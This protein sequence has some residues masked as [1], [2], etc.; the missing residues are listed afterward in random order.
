MCENCHKKKDRCSKKCEKKCKKCC[1]RGPV[2]PTGAQGPTGQQG[3]TGAQGPTGPAGIQGPTGPAGIQGSTGQQGPTGSPGV[4]GPTGPQGPTGA[5][6]PLIGFA[7]ALE[8]PT[9]ATGNQQIFLTENII[10]FNNDFTQ[11]FFDTSNIYDVFTGLFIVPVTGIYNITT[12]LLCIVNDNSDFNGSLNF[13][14]KIE[15]PDPNDIKYINTLTKNIA[16]A[17]AYEIY[18][19]SSIDLSLNQDDQVSIIIKPNGLSSGVFDAYVKGKNQLFDQE[20][21]FSYPSTF[22]AALIAQF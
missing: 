6:G 22:S 17:T 10:L 11:P 5:L 19:N 13:Y 15:R 8:G 4:D 1:K 21:A 7:A 20:L 2:G 3:S 9:G 16:S 14:I 18:Y 12:R